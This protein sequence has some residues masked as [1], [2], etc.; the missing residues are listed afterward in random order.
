MKKLLIANWKMYLSKV[1]TINLVKKIKKLSVKK[2]EMTVAPA[3]VYFE[4]VSK[5]LKTGSIKMTA[6]NVAAY[7]SGAHT[8]EISA[9]MLKEFGCRYALVGHS[10]RRLE[11][12]ETDPLIREKIKRLFEK[13]ITPVLCVGE[14][15]KQKFS[16]ERNQVVVQQLK[17]ALS[18]ID[19]LVK[20]KLVVAY[21]P[22]WAIGT[23]KVVAIKDLEEVF[24]V[25]K[26]ALSMLESEDYFNRQVLFLYGGSLDDDNIE[27][28]ASLDYLCG[29]LVGR[30]STNADKLEK[31]IKVLG[32]F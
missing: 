4:A 29:F 7:E 14:T 3:A 32:S 1:E 9:M 8:G 17:N 31:I 10:E 12:N 22:V 19:S 26:R 5:L 15:A 21:E 30:A 23:G 27:Q 13:N 6:Q 2:I 18:G 28:F 20:K 24:G 16:G 25:I 11:L